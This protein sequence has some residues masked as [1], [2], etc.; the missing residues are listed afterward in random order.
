[1]KGNLP[2]W[3]R[4]RHWN[5][6]LSG[7]IPPTSGYGVKFA[8][9]VRS[10]FSGTVNTQV[11]PLQDPLNP[12][13]VDPE[14]ALGTIVI[15]EPTG[16]I[17]RQ[18]PDFVP[19]AIEHARPPGELDTEPLPVPPPDSTVMEPG[20]ARRYSACTLRDAVSGTLQA[21]VPLHAP[22]QLR[23]TLPLVGVCVTVTTVFSAYA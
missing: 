6:T 12:V 8:V 14:L 9:T 4:F 23:N 11:I 7:K 10:P 3:R 2:E 20:T 13:N 16:K 15:V 18:I 21:P 19:F 1:V 17:A 22:T 5:D